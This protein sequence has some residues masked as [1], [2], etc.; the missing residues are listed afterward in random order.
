MVRSPPSASYGFL[1]I[2]TLAWH[3][4]T[5]SISTIGDKV[6]CRLN[7]LVSWEDIGC[8]LYYCSHS[9]GQTSFFKPVHDVT[10][11]KCHGYAI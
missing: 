7:A 6:M 11:A 4:Q 1:F 3:G 2:T 5:L 10:N 8:L 9:G